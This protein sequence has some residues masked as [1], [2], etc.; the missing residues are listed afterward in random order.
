MGKKTSK[1]KETK[2]WRGI[3]QT[4]GRQAV[5][6]I[7]RKRKIV[8]HAKLC[9]VILI[10][11]LVAGGI[12]YS[13]HFF[14][15]YENQII[16]AGPSDPVRRINFQS[17]GEL[18]Y[19]WF[20]RNVA[21]PQDKTIMEIDIFAIKQMLENKGQIASAVVSRKFPDELE[22]EIIE[23]EPVLRARVKG[24]KG[25]TDEVYVARD[26][27]VYFHEDYEK[28]KKKHLPYLGGVRFKQDDDHILSLPGMDV[29]SQLLDTARLN[30]PI[31]FESWKVVSCEE[32]NG[33]NEFSDEIIKIRSSIVREIIFTP[34]DFSRQ[35][36]Q[37]AR[38]IEYSK[39]N[40]IY[41]IKRIDL[42][43]SDQVAVQF[44]P[45]LGLRKFRN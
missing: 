34:F 6:I 44:Y 21:W 29:I 15:S 17:N 24:K 35:L 23:R 3:K 30:Y 45:D 31:L 4:A 33:L 14:R 43:V 28:S 2:N 8:A 40:H 9:G 25:K 42:S 27:T 16:L 39:R 32:F 12:T 41:N 22:I 7:A 19:Q 11:L 10:I 13:V 37:L 26:G 38:V 20:E 1:S 18:D 36:D 5:S